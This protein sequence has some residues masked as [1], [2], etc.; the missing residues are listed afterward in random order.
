MTAISSH[1]AGPS[2]ASGLGNLMGIAGGCCYG[3][4][5]EIAG[6]KGTKM[7]SLGSNRREGSL[8]DRLEMTRLSL[9]IL[10]LAQFFIKNIL[11]QVIMEN[12]ALSAFS[13]GRNMI[14]K[15]PSSSSK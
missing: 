4:T 1:S 14:P 15:W 8:G 11:N 9:L 12:I 2:S 3:A 6:G 5:A 13:S 10:P 7:H